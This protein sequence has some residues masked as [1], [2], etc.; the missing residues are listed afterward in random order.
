ME[1]AEVLSVLDKIIHLTS[2]QPGTDITKLARWLRCLFNLA[3]TYDES[4][5][6]KCTD[7][8]IALAAKH[9]GVCVHSFVKDLELSLNQLN[10][11]SSPT[12]L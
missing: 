2:L 6:L 10:I 8:A 4:I 5:S 12:H 1:R 3:L 9:Q 7:E 11:V